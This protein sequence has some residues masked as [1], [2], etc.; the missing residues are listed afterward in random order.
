MLDG[1]KQLV[2][3]RR[4]ARASE[5]QAEALE[6]LSRVATD[7]WNA[8]YPPR[9][10]R[11]NEVEFGVATFGDIDAATEARLER[12]SLGNYDEPSS[13]T[14]EAAPTPH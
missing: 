2:I 3:L 6:A 11:G 12:E 10:G 1:L 5:R 14:G 7:W 8:K 4:I 13:E 9:M